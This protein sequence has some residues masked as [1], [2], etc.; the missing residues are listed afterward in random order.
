MELEVIV[1]VLRAAMDADTDPADHS[2]RALVERSAHL[3]EEFTGGDA[4]IYEALATQNRNEPA[5]RRR[6]GMD[7]DVMAYASR[8]LLVMD[9]TRQQSDGRK[10]GRAEGR[11]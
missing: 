9:E 4:A 3:I 10:D 5:V 2:V 11:A 6:V 1:A 8:A 7:P